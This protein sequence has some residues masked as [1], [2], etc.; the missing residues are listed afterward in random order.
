M[1]TSPQ[2]ISGSST[3]HFAARFAALH[4]K[5]NR[6]RHFLYT[7][8]GNLLCLNLG[9]VKWC[10]V[11]CMD[12]MGMHPPA[13]PTWPIQI[14]DYHSFIIKSGHF[15]DDKWTF[16]LCAQLLKLPLVPDDQLGQL[17]AKQCLRIHLGSLIPPGEL[18]NSTLSLPDVIAPQ[19]LELHNNA[20]NFSKISFFLIWSQLIRQGG[21]SCNGH[22]W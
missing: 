11:T 21:Q 9:L 10:K 5:L 17:K 3:I 20:A 12:V 2:K 8:Y 16:G 22:A 13:M 1:P 4:W 7:L 19:L 15:P 18:P 14:L 6:F